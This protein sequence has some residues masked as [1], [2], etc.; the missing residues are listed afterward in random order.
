MVLGCCIWEPRAAREQVTGASL[1]VT[2][3]SSAAASEAVV[4]VSATSASYTGS[5]IYGGKGSAMPSG[6]VVVSAA[7]D[8]NHGQAGKPAVRGP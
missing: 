2:S 4:G 6:Y 5:L 7:I 8:I 3:P 1:T